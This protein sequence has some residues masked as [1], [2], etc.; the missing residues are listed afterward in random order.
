[1]PVPVGT[2][3]VPE[4]TLPVREPAASGPV[5]LALSPVL[6]RGQQPPAR[7]RIPEATEA[8]LLELEGD[9]DL[10][11]PSAA[12]LEAAIETVEGGEVWRGE[13]RRVRDPRRG[14][15]LAATRVPA[16]NLAAGDYLLTLSVSGNADG[17]LHRYFFRVAR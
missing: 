7:L 10:L 6:L 13:A 15:L 14:S 1:M 17:T 5:V 16:A 11:P 9:A 3:A 12:T 8:V 4:P 2:S